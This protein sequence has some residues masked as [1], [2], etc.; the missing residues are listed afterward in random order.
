[1]KNVG[2]VIA[3]SVAMK[4]LFEQEYGVKVRVLPVPM[5]VSENELLRSTFVST[6]EP[7][8]IGYLGSLDAARDIPFLFDVLE[9]LIQDHAYSKATLKLIG[10]SENES[11]VQALK[12]EVLERKI[13]NIVEFTGMLDRED[14]WR[15]VAKCDVCV[16]YIPRSRVYD[17]SSPT[18]LVEYLSLG[19]KVVANDIPDQVYFMEQLNITGISGSD[20]RAFT[21]ELKRKFV[22][23]QVNVST[24]ALEIRGYSSIGLSLYIDLQHELV[25]LKS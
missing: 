4:D 16:S 5:G 10:G 3:Q 2:L 22:E 7:L 23:D 20:V 8:S 21:A 24:K 15:R 9:L 12:H 14:A 6:I 1:M 19:K 13:D 25:S 18:K 11:V 17:V